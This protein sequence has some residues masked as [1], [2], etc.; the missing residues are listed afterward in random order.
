MKLL[1]QRPLA[2]CIKLIMLFQVSI[3][4][5]LFGSSGA[6][7]YYVTP[8]DD[9][10]ADDDTCFFEGRPLRPCSTLETLAKS[11]SSVYHHHSRSG[12]FELFFFPGDYVLRNNMYLTFTSFQVSLSPLMDDGSPI[13]IKCNAEMT[14]TFQHVTIAII[15]SLE[16]H[17]CGG[18]I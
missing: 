12:N 1:S 3:I 11:Y 8:S 14:I 10:I 17:S 9:I 13:K 4:V 18:K 16:F 15:K 5:V 7:P 6:I 2:M